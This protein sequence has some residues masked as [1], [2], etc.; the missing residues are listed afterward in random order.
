MNQKQYY[1]YIMTNHSKTL[2]I[3]VTNDLIRRVWEHKQGLVSGFTKKYR[4]KKL[5]YFEQTSDVKS[6]ITREKE[7]KGWLRGKKIAL[8]ESTNPMWKD[9]YS[10]LLL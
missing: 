4:I 3:G 7:L 9:L 6:A 1:I 8:I 2:Y 10:D 5:V